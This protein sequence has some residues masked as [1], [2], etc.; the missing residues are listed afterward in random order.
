[1]KLKTAKLEGGRRMTSL[2]NFCWTWCLEMSR[3]M[4]AR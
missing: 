1:M 2:E 3:V 4:L